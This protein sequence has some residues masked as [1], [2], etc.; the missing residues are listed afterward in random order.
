MMNNRAARNPITVGFIGILILLMA[1]VSAF[2]LEKL[3]IIGAGITYTADFTEAAGLKPGNEVRIAG[4][5]VGNVDSVELHKGK[6]RV[7]FRTGG[8][9]IGNQAQAAIQIRT[10]LGQKYLGIMPG[11][12]EKADPAQIITRTVSPYDVVEA[13]SDAAKNV[14]E[15]DTPKL[16]ES[17][18]TL[19]D[20]FSGT[21]K[22]MR[23]SLLGI[24]RLSE[25]I[26]SR[27]QQVQ[28][29]LG[30]TAKTS[31]ILADRNQ[32]FVRLISSMGQLMQE[33]NFRQKNISRL[34]SSTVTIST[35]LSGIIRDNQSQIGPVLDNLKSVAGILTRQNKNLREALKYL[36]PFY[37]L[38]ANVLGNGR[39]FEQVVTNLLPPGLPAQNTTRLPNKTNQRNNGGTKET[40]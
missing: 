30:A 6:A 21:P 36:G 13:F 25:T 40:K 16:E 10:V 15:I 14:G 29:L 8:A 18:S 7:K 4:V 22:D 26:S 5:K 17:L 34:L 38:Y 31:K 27:D 3:P 20:A 35:A 11:G 32:E 23:A 19:T 1:T 33:L 37:R 24:K 2:S 12:T 28:K 39:W 9:W